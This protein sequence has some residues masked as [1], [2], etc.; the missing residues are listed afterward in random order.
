LWKLDF[1]FDKSNVLVVGK[2]VNKDKIWNLC[3]STISTCD[4]YKYLGVHIA[5]NLSDHTHV[6]EVV[7]KGNRLISYIKSIL[8][9]HDDFN[10]VQYGDILWRTIALPCINY[11]CAA[12][13]CGGEVDV[14]RVENLQLQMARYILKAPRNT[15]AAALYGDLG[16]Q[17]I[18]SIQESIKISYFA[19]LSSMSMH[20]WP[21]LL[22]NSL[23]ILN[24]CGVDQTRF[25]WLGPVK[26]TLDKCDMNHLLID[27]TPLNQQWVRSFKMI[28]KGVYETSWRDNAKT[29]SSLTDYV[30]FKHFLVLENYLLEKTDFIGINLTFKAR[31]NTLS[32]NGRTHRW[33]EDSDDTCPLCKSGKEDLS[34][35]LFTCR[36]LNYIRSEEYLKLER[37]LY[38]KN[39]E[40]LWQ[41][42]IAGDLDVKKCCMLGTSLDGTDGE[43]CFDMFCKSF[44]KKAWTFRSS[45]LK[46]NGNV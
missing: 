39:Q 24:Q 2:Q 25:K 13:T 33:K 44:L 37:D 42:F 5:K 1:N 18:A 7:K 22:F 14:K 9:G 26:N 30:K 12:W 16:W 36:S 43:N 45:T 15:P 27:D 20:R 29:K 31:S 3:D 38:V 6:N 34:H 41:M 46:D 21:K 8:D 28:N 19:R 11:G 23:R 17:S 40:V 4:S 35:F 10:R 32:L